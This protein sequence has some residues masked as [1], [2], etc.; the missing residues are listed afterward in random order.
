M[1]ALAALVTITAALFYGII[2]FRTP[3]DVA[4]VTCADV[5]LDAACGAPF[6]TPWRERHSARARERSGRRS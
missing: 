4:I 2:R 5:A 6:A 1:V 3:A